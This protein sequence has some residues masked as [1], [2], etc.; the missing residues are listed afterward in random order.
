MRPL[1]LLTLLAACAPARE[2]PALDLSEVPF[3]NA[4]VLP[5]AGA[6]VR[7]LPLDGWQCPDG[8]AARVHLVRG[9]D[10]GADAALLLHGGNFDW[11]DSIGLHYAQEDRLGAAW[12]TR[13]VDE[14]LGVPSAQPEGPARGAWV[15]ALLDAGMP[16][17]VP[18]GCWGDLWHGRGDND[19]DSEGFLRWGADFLVDAWEAGRTALEADGAT[20]A[21]GLGEGGRGVVELLRSGARFDAI[22]VDGSP[23]WLSPVLS[24]PVGNRAYIEGLE[25][26]WAADL[27]GLVDADERA[28]ALREALRDASFVRLVDEGLRTPILYAYSETD[29]AVPPELSRPAAVA[30]GTA[31]PNGTFRVIEWRQD[32]ATAVSAAS[33]TD[34]DEV[35]A[36]LE[37]FLL[38]VLRPAR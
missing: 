38:P 22:A 26:I 12:G 10:A 16:L 11:V 5:D 34:P 15:K 37:G 21:V 29:P 14:L 17:V 31:Y 28:D 9:P 25:N 23:D 6:T 3:W 7:V 30:I 8:S 19:L 36:Q 20:L 13:A 35:A 32:P 4:W 18:V 27:A 1:L 2:W 33:N 24:D